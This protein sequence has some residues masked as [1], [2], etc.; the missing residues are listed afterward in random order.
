MKKASST[1]AALPI[2]YHRD[3]K[4]VLRFWRVWTEGACVVSEAGQ[5]GTERA[6]QSRVHCEPKNVGRANATTAEQQAVLEAQAQWNKKLKR[7]YSEEVP[8]KSEVL[9]HLPMLAQPFYEK[10][11]IT[12]HGKKVIFPVDV[13]PKING[14]R[15]SARW[16]GKRVVLLSKSG[17]PWKLLH[18]PQQLESW[19]PKDMILD[20]ELYV[21]GAPLG[22]I[23]SL[24]AKPTMESMA[25]EYHVFDVPMVQGS[26]TMPWMN[27]SV[28]L[29]TE[30]KA[31]GSVKPLG[32]VQVAS[33][34]ELRAVHQRF[35]ERGFEGAIIRNPGGFYKHGYRSP[36]LLKVKSRLS[37]EFVVTGCTEGRGKDEGT[38]TFLCRTSAGVEFGARM[39]GTIDQRR[40]YWKNREDYY[41]RKLTVEFFEWTEHNT[42]HQPVG[43]VF[44]DPKDLT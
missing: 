41:G 25:L 20:G 9:D 38:A 36:D 35:R 13:Q 40:A 3:S 24:C 21:H 23:L 1:A 26:R 7:K 12:S 42:P 14:V 4:G 39:R 16:E 5:D 17:D 19:M 6:V 31:T 2:L 18:I 11:N 8:K 30:V 32:S 34:D 43:I 27:R 15:A 22:R 33:I 10:G 44:R 28:A 29:R 37:E